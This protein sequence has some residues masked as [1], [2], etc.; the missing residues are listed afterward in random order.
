VQNPLRFSAAVFS[1]FHTSFSEKLRLKILVFSAFRFLALYIYIK[2]IYMK[3]TKDLVKRTDDSLIYVIRGQKVM[4][5][6]D[7]ARIYGVETRRLNE[8]VKRNLD[9]FPKDFM[10]QVTEKEY[11]IL[12]SQFATSS[13]EEHLKSQPKPSKKDSKALRSSAEE[14]N[15]KS[16]FVTSGWGGRRKLPYVFTEHG[17]VMLA[18]V[19]NSPKAV[20]ASIQVVKAFVRLRELITNNK[21]LSKRLDELEENYDKQFAVVFDAIRRLMTPPPKEGDRKRIGYRRKSEE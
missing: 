21:T 2:P 12:M 20:H 4:L 10:F 9:R 16:K 7:L 18:S 13:E 14:T 8:Q 1:V 17:T 15:L 11:E 19:L 5:D 6:E 3:A